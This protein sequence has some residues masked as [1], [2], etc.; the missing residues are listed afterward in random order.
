MGFIIQIEYIDNLREFTFNYTRDL[1]YCTPDP[2]KA[3]IQVTG[4]EKLVCNVFRNASNFY[5]IK[6]FL[7]LGVSCF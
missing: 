7:K 6:Q 1:N 2:L 4:S 5:L 3:H